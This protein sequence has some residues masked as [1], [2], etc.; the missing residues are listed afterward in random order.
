MLAPKPAKEPTKVYTFTLP[1]SLVAEIDAIAAAE[2]RPRVGQ[3][4]AFLIEAVRAW[5]D[6][7]ET[8]PK[9]RSA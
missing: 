4:T 9:R 7:R 8:A 2:H 1:P 6:A 3:V 5:H